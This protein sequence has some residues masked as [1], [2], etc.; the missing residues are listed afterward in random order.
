MTNV[1][2]SVGLVSPPRPALPGP[3]AWA[4]TQTL[5]KARF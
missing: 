4:G 5:G 3:H 2:E 1:L